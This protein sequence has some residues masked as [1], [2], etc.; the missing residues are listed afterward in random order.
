MLCPPPIKSICTKTLDVIATCFAPPPADS[1]TKTN[2]QRQ[3]YCFEHYERYSTPGQDNSCTPLTVIETMHNPRSSPPETSEQ[4]QSGPLRTLLIESSEHDALMLEQELRKGGLNPLI[5]RVETP[6]EL[7]A[8]LTQPWAIILAD[9]AL[10]KLSALYALEIVRKCGKDIPCIV[11]SS[12]IG[13]ENAALVM[14]SGACDYI[15]KSNLSRLTPAVRRELQEAQRREHHRLTQQQLVESQREVEQQ[16]QHQ[17]EMRLL[18]QLVSGVAHEVRNPLNA[19]GALFEAFFEEIAEQ[20][21]F[22]EYHH[23]IKLQVERL[24]KLMIDMMEMGQPLDQAS[25]APINL[26]ELCTEAAEVW[27]MSHQSSQRPQV[28][29]VMEC[30]ATSCVIWGDFKRLHSVLLHLF[31]NAAHHAPADSLITLRL[32]TLQNTTLIIELEDRGQG[33]K[34]QFIERVFE[35]FFTTRTAGTGLGLSIVRH[36]IEAHEGSVCLCNNTPPPGCTVQI[37]LQL[38]H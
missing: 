7:E 29:L 5:Q 9:F 19:I 18:E 26:T 33:I 21:P 30:G 2:T 10:P 27:N 23:H 17:R 34:P 36:I 31:E 1:D 4:S 15:T 8:A 3:T 14:R 16:H 38:H 22:K 11:V 25:F 28:E 13:E 20:E 24:T 32:R 6:D 37:K 35:P 12:N